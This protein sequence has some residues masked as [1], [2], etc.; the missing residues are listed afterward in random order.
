MVKVRDE[1]PTHEDG[2]VNLESWLARVQEKTSFSESDMAVIASACELS[3]LAEQEAVAVDNIWAE[4]TS[5]FRTGIEIAEILLDLHMD[6]DSVVAGI[7]Y[8]SVREQKLPLETI[9]EQLGTPVSELVDGVLQM[10]AISALLRPERRGMADDYHLQMDNMRKMLVSMVDD[11]RVALIKLAERTCA[12]R[13]VSEASEEKQ[14]RVAQEVF[15]VYAPLAHRLGIGHI[16]WELEDLSFRYLQTAAYKKIAGLL[17][18]KRLDR[19][20][21]IDDVLDELG[22]ALGKDGVPAE[23][24]GRVKHIY[25][26]WRKM[27][28]KN[29]DFHQVYD[30]R[31][32]RILVKDDKECYAALGV[33]H[34]LWQH[35]Y[36]EFDDYITTPKEN[37]YRSLHTAV[38]GP[39]GK[40]LEVQ[41]RTQEMHEEAELGV[42]AHWQYKDGSSGRSSSGSYENKINWL[43]QV[44]EWHEDLGD[45]D[46]G[47]LVEQFQNDVVEDRIYVFTRDGDVKDLALGATPLDFAYHIHTEVGNRCRG[48]EVNGRIVPLNYALKTGE[49]VEIITSKHAE[50]RRDWLNANSG[51]IRTPRAR[52]KV[53]HW[54]KFQ[55]RDK[56]VSDGLALLSTE[57]QRL[58]ITDVDQV[59]VAQSLN[60]KAWE[61]VA[62]AVGAG[63]VKISQVV[64]KTDLHLNSPIPQRGPQ[65][66]APRSDLNLQGVIIQGVGNLMTHLAGCCKPVAGDAISGYVTVGRGITIHGQSCGHLLQLQQEDPDRVLEVSWGETSGQVYPVEILI[67]AYDRQGLLRDVTSVLALE[68][69]NVIAMNTRSD[70]SSNMAELRVTL[71]VV[72]IATLGKLLGKINQ[73]PNVISVKRDVQA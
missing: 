53:Q 37:G 11:V 66:S 65:L 71:E 31:A 72:S 45:A 49:R 30:I 20:E 16:K 47:D 67:S 70:V 10:A 54:F 12:I 1:H 17:V 3:R 59:K 51:Y 15:D 8:R 7:I 22:P 9:V 13:A 39:H 19:E 52:A 26:I 63:D 61:D 2:S 38:I 32:V 35:I 73:L 41:I 44:L 62:A 14:R 36:K 27:R 24:S 29:I 4:G 18:E 57:F 69:A 42:C 40:V 55:D 56:N 58:A 68:N 48:A 43:R 33:V 21:Y 46:L 64:A 25:S 50:P 28:R 34:S 5:S 6:L 23:L 60:Y